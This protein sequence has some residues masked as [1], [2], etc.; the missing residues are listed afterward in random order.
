MAT[1]KEAQ[2]RGNGQSAV[3]LSGKLLFEPAEERENMN[4]QNDRPK[5][6]TGYVT[7]MRSHD[8][9]HF[10]ISMPLP[11]NPTPNDADCVRKECAR[12]V[13]K[14]VKQYQRHK[15]IE[16]AMTWDKWQRDQVFKEAVEIRKI[17]AKDWTPE[18]KAVVKSWEDYC[19]A[20][21]HGEYDYEDE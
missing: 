13:D 14:A 17:P 6:G 21:D 19:F 15:A 1:A 8:Y 16:V 5:T 11:E 18:Q 10:E 7:V 4:K 9:C 20:A 2:E 3:R 12:L